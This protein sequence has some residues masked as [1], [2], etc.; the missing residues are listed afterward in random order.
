[1]LSYIFGSVSVSV[2]AAAA[3]AAAATDVVTTVA[4]G[5]SIIISVH[6]SRLSSS[7]PLPPFSPVVGEGAAAGEGEGAAAVSGEALLSKLGEGEGTE[8]VEALSLTDGL[9][10]L[11]CV[12]T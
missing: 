1:M 10:M 8:V 7:S 12:A 5:C 3:V 11:H 9:E 6:V 4:A 2:V